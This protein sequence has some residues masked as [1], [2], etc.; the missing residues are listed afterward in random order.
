MAEHGAYCDACHAREVA[1]VHAHD[2]EPVGGASCPP[3]WDA[4]LRHG[5]GVDPHADRL[6]GR[7][8][9]GDKR[10]D[11]IHVTEDNPWQQNAIKLM[12]D[13]DAGTQG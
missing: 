10:H 6:R 7:H 11:E 1:K 9:G 4:A 2:G 13:A 3:E 12:E 8:A 5:G